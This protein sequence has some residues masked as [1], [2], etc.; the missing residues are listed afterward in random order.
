MGCT[1]EVGVGGVGLLG[2]HLIRKTCPLH[3]RGHL[4]PA[5]ELVNESGVEPGLVDLEVGI[6]EQAVAIEALDIVAFESGAVAPDVDVVLLHCG[7]QHGAGHG[8]AYRSGVEVGDTGSGDVEGASLERGDA[9][10]YQRAAA[11]DQA[12]LFG[13]VFQGRARDRVVVGF[14]G[15]AQVSCIGVR[16]G[17]LLPH[18]VQGGRGVEPAGESNADFLPRGQ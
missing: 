17:P 9:L 16:N 18:P 5:A 4:G 12:G 14:V 2:G 1:Q 13:A 7:H 8:A 10:A 6:D 3:E 11:V 15:L